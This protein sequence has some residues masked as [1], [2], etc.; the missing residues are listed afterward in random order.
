MKVDK[1][2]RRRFR[3][4]IFTRRAAVALRREAATHEDP[5]GWLVGLKERVTE[6]GQD[7]HLIP[8]HAILTRAVK[9]QGRKDKRPR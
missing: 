3:R 8:G 9:V 4:W 2:K 7:F 5:Y 1:L 6:S